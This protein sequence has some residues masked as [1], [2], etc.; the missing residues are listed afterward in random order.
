MY[1]VP[2]RDEVWR[3][4]SVLVPEGFLGRMVFTTRSELIQFECWNMG[5]VKVQDGYSGFAPWR[6]A[7]AD[8]VRKAWRRIKRNHGYRAV[9]VIVRIASWE[10]TDAR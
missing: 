2:D 8:E 4:W 3:G 5:E 9:S 7:D 10:A 1:E 6:T